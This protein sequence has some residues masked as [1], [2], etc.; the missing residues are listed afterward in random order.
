MP[1]FGPIIDPGSQIGRRGLR[2]EAQV[3]DYRFCTVRLELI[4]FHGGGV[5]ITLIPPQPMPM[6]LKAVVVLGVMTVGPVPWLLTTKLI[7][8]LSKQ[9]LFLSGLDNSA[10]TMCWYFPWINHCWSQIRFFCLGRTVW[11]ARSGRW[12]AGWVHSQWTDL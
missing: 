1:W 3:V 12:E 9:H 6:L 10:W 7:I 8:I 11:Q 4:R 5:C 2:G